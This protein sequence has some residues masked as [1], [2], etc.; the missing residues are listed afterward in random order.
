MDGDTRMIVHALTD[1]Q[2]PV[3]KGDGGGGAKTTTAMVGQ[4]CAVDYS[5]W[6]F[7]ID[8]ESEASIVLQMSQVR[9]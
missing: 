1:T 5:I 7:Y 8:G 3:G 9:R 6:R 4:R 2:P